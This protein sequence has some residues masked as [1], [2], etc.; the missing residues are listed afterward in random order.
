LFAIAKEA[1]ITRDEHEQLFMRP[2]LHALRL[3]LAGGLAGGAVGA[4]ISTI[5]QLAGR[6][7]MTWRKF[8]E[9]TPK[10]VL[11]GSGLGAVAGIAA[12]NH[13]NSRSEQLRRAANNHWD[14]Q[15]TRWAERE[16]RVRAT[17]TSLSAPT[18]DR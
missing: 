11:L 12:A 9:T 18:P 16:T 15:E 6:G 17:A 7:S 10:A 8:V 4:A 14:E 3:G 5:I 2:H 13:V 1:E